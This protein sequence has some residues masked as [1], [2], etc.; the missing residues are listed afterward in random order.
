MSL[1]DCVN[2]LCLHPAAAFC[3]RQLTLLLLSDLVWPAGLWLFMCRVIGPIWPAGQ[4]R[5]RS[6][7]V[8]CEVTGAFTRPLTSSPLTLT[9]TKLK[10][11]NMLVVP[12]PHLSFLSV[13]CCQHSVSVS[14]LRDVKTRSCRPPSEV[15]WPACDH[16][17][18]SVFVCGSLWCKLCVSVLST[19]QRCEHTFSTDL[20]LVATT[21]P[22][23]LYKSPYFKSCFMTRSL[24]NFV[25][26]FL[27][28]I[29]NHWCL[30]VYSALNVI[31]ESNCHP[32]FHQTPFTNQLILGVVE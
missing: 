19:C 18:Q 26:H 21:S 32:Q 8:H 16:I 23:S 29:L 6:I 7:S 1:A 3:L 14:G 5:L 25:K 31:H 24:M 11:K 15:I 17:H 22:D 4:L 10:L 12:V 20:E 13:T 28:Q 9:L 30:L 27:W 2:C